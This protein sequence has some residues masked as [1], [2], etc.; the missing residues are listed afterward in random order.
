MT[1]ETTKQAIIFTDG[2]CL[3]NPG[4]GGYAALILIDGKEQIIVGRDA[5]TTNNKMEM[6]AAIKV[7]D[8]VPHSAPIIIHS[9]SQYVIKGATQWLPGWKTKGW[10][11]ADGKP[12]LNQELWMQMDQLISGRKITWQWVKGH[13]GHEQNERVDRLANTEAQMAAMA[14][15]FAGSVL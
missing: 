14:V 10:R 8:A 9:D 1:S 3:K 2:A 6:T 12:V 13:A 15:G 11:K 4:P 5:A 7:L